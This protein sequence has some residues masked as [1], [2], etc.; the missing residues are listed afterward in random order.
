MCTGE[1]ETRK[2]QLRQ[3]AISRVCYLSMWPVWT[4]RPRVFVRE[5][6]MLGHGHAPYAML[7]ILSACADI[8][9]NTRMCVCFGVLVLAPCGVRLRALPS[10]QRPRLS[11]CFRRRRASTGST[12]ERYGL[13]PGRRN[14]YRRRLLMRAT[15]PPTHARELVVYEALL[16]ELRV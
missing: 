9:A 12:V 16:L 13:P 3:R 5:A 6:L 2:L 4:R 7:C 14:R 10:P 8:A 1:I 15:T 11:R